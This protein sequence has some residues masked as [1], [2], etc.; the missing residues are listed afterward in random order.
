MRVLIILAAIIIGTVSS[1][2][3]LTV[4]KQKTVSGW[5][6]L[7]GQTKYDGQTCQAMKCKGGC[8]SKSKISLN[9]WGSKRRRAITPLLGISTNY[10]RGT[11]ATVMVAGKKFRFHKSRK[12]RTTKFLPIRASDD[13]KFIRAL[14]N[15]QARNLVFRAR[16]ETVSLSTSGV[17]NAIKYIDAQCGIR[18]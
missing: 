11:K 5:S 6:A 7:V 10:P 9:L 16:N 1:A 3:A 17:H 14:L 8:S 4:Q 2:S 13:A 15:A 18:R 12:N